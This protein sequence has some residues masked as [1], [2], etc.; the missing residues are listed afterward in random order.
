MSQNILR[1][2]YS[3][4]ALF[5]HFS[6]RGDMV[7]AKTFIIETT[8]NLYEY[9]ESV[10]ESIL[11]WIKIHPC[12]SAH[13]QEI[14]KNGLSSLFYVRAS[15]D[16]VDSLS[17]VFLLRFK[18]LNGT[19]NDLNNECWHLIL[20]KEL[21][22]IFKTESELLWRL[23]I[24]QLS[25][26][27]YAITLNIYHGVSDGSNSFAI[28]EELL[29]IIETSIFSSLQ[30]PT[31]D[32]IKFRDYEI[33]YPNDPRQG[34]NLQ[35]Y[36]WTATEPQKMIIVPDYFKFPQNEYENEAL[37]DGVYETIDGIFYADYKNLT[38]TI[39][40]SNTGHLKAK[41]DNQVFKK[42]V[43]K[44]KQNQVKL[45]ALFEMICCLSFKKLYNQNEN[46]VYNVTINARPHLP[47]PIPNYVMSVWVLHGYSANEEG[48]L[49]EYENFSNNFWDNVCKKS[50]NLHEFIHDLKQTKLSKPENIWKFIEMDK[51]GYRVNDVFRHFALTNLG[52]QKSSNGKLKIKEY[53]TGVSFNPSS[54]IQI[55]IAGTCSID[56][57]S[58]W[59]FS[60]NRSLIKD[61]LAKKFLDFVL[62]FISKISELDN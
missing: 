62:E 16:L 35:N 56:L 55:G 53:Y 23:I 48:S 12:L 60:Y 5:Y 59:T 39:K 24:L 37:V 11:H 27:K 21:N 45:N 52:N 13:I 32:R 2:Q 58:Y 33:N 7:N 10:K 41:I 28:I 54:Y 46:I 40:S 57:N 15:Q 34:A 50:R 61:S 14:E 20:Q 22:Y 18:T 30:E 31:S 17:N 1:E 42:L 9:T 44:C 36:I 19:S 51:Q 3:E 4:E 43:N 8:F 49:E 47:I 6:K 29:S 25:E 26:F 38:E